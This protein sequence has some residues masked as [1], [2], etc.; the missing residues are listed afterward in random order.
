M[1]VGTLASGGRTLHLLLYTSL[2]ENE[3]TRRIATYIEIVEPKAMPTGQVTV[4]A[5]AIASGLQADGKVTL[6]GLLFD[7]GKTDIKPDSAAQL[8]QMVAVL[9]AQPTAKVFIV[10]HTDNVGSV[11]A[12]VKLSQGR[13]Q[14]VVA[15]LTQR[16]VASNSSED[17][18]ARNRRVE[19]VLQ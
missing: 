2:A 4:D 6:S 3:Y 14:A 19:M 12:N 1:T 15:A 18:R 8:D 9:K 5:K 16:G 11:D 17:G 7:T 10:G 13:A